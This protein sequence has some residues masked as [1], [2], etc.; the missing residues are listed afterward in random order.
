MAEAIELINE[1]IEEKKQ[2]ENFKIFLGYTSNMISCGMR[3]LIRFLCEHKMVDGIVTT[4][5]GIEEDI[6]K[7]YL[8]AYIGQFRN[9]DTK[10]KT[11]GINRIGN[12]FVPNENYCKFS[13]FIVD[14][15]NDLYLDQNKDKHYTPS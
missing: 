15:I 1:M 12:M 13:D 7:C 8:P 3:E 2:N 5:G 9:N 4:C 10:L 6:M 14:V 11:D